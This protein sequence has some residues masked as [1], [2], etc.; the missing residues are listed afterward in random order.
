MRSR[1]DHDRRAP[2]SYRAA[3]LDHLIE[4]LPRR[5]FILFHQEGCIDMKRIRVWRRYGIGTAQDLLAAGFLVEVVRDA[6]SS[7][8]AENRLAGFE[9]MVRLGAGMTTVEMV[10]F[11][12]LREAG[13]AAFNEIS[14]MVR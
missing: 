3:V 10:L 1:Y 2:L 4:Y 5:G 14:R 7:R 6:V 9:R 11:E 13:S 12:W 8:T